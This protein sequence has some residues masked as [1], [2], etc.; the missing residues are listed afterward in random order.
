MEN[1]DLFQ[2]Q[3][4]LS[5]KDLIIYNSE[6]QKKVKSVGLAYFL[7]IFFAGLGL[8]KFYLGKIAEGIIYLI[9]GTVDF[10]F[11]QFIIFNADRNWE[12]SAFVYILFGVSGIFLLFDLLTLSTQI[13]QQEKVLRRDLLAKFGITVSKFDKPNYTVV[14]P[15]ENINIENINFECDNALERN[16]DNIKLNDSKMIY[17]DE[18]SFKSLLSQLKIVLKDKGLLK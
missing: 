11:L 1:D 4:Q 15:N 17:S 3:R 6:L 7:L 16:I 12:P 14:S 9:V 18:Y 5:E 8:H 13:S 10:V 2:A